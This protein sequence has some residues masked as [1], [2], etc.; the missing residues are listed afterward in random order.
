MLSG[1]I[2]TVLYIKQGLP[3]QIWS[4]IK[5]F[6][7]KPCLILNQMEP[8]FPN[9]VGLSLSTTLQEQIEVEFSNNG[10]IRAYLR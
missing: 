3:F 10:S 6:E 9:F 4:C 2:R 5:L 7:S 8:L 1:K